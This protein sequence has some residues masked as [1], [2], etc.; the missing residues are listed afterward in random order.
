VKLRSPIITAQSEKW[1]DLKTNASTTF[2]KIKDFVS[3]KWSNIKT[4]TNEKWNAIKDK[5]S[6]TWSTLKSKS[7]DS[8][9]NIKDKVTEAW[10]GL[11]SKTKSLWDGI[12]GVIKTP[13]NAIIGFI[14]KMIDGIATGINSLIGMLNNLKI[15]IPDGVPFVGGMKIGFDIPTFDPLLA[16][17]AVIPPNKEFLAILGDQKHGTNI[18]APEGLIRSIMREE[19]GKQR[20]VSGKNITIRIPVILNGSQLFE[21]IIDE[22]KL[23]QAQNGMDPFRMA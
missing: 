23:R 12:K 4:A 1:G 18:E 5:L 8:A 13:I 9:G 10:E 17:G 16:T 11:K 6:D 20:D 19:L 22:G 3:D 15:D 14:N 21:A 2:G 7:K